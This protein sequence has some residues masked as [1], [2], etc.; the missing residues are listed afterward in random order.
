MRGHLCGWPA[1]ILSRGFCADV[2]AQTWTAAEPITPLPDAPVVR[3]P[4]PTVRVAV[5]DP[6]V[7]G[8]QVLTPE[9]VLVQGPRS[10]PP[11]SSS[12]ARREKRPAAASS[13]RLD[14]RKIQ[15]ALQRL[16]PPLS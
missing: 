2:P 10:A 3:A 14:S 12:G 8:V 5:T 16:F 9:Q 7:A 11:T 13:S 15:V 6:I 1:A 4:W